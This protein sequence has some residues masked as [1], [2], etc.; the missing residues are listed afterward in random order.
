MHTCI[1]THA[2]FSAR[3]D[4]SYFSIDGKTYFHFVVSTTLC[5][6]VTHRSSTESCDIVYGRENWPIVPHHRLDG[7]P[8]GRDWSATDQS[9]PRY[10]P[11]DVNASEICEFASLG[12]E[13]WSVRRANVCSRRGCE[14]RRTAVP[15]VRSAARRRERLSRARL[16]VVYISFPF[17]L[18]LARSLSPSSS[19]ARLLS[20]VCRPRRRV[21]QCN[22]CEAIRARSFDSKTFLG[23]VPLADRYAGVTS[24]FAVNRRHRS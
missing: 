9:A 24:L 21:R 15:D 2:K 11:R 4:I 20:R 19:A 12:A 3:A 16:Y 18:F 17:S 22:L 14:T 13:S 7:K 6:L 5:A 1:H 8:D 10:N 23:S